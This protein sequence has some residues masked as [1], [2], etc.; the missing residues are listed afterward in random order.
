MKINYKNKSS[1]FILIQTLAL[2]VLMSSCSL[3]D[4]EAPSPSL[5]YSNLKRFQIKEGSSV[6]NNGEHFILAEDVD[7]VTLDT[8]KEEIARILFLKK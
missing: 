8:H 4:S 6:Y 2:M 5:R 1:K 7:V 3:T